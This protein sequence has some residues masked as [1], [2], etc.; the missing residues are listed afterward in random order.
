[1]P[2]PP[3]RVGLGYDT[4]KL[5]NGGPLRLGGIDIE[6]NVHAIGHSDADV[7]L[8]AMTDALLGAADLGDIGQLFPDTDERN[9]GRESSEF[10][11]E[12][13]RRV[14]GAGWE[15]VNLDSVVLTQRPKIA[16]YLE[17][18]KNRVGEITNLSPAHIGIKGKTG[19][20]VGAIGHAE[21]ISA[22]CVTL[23]YRT[24]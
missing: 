1:M 19:E 22:R 5:G 21:A 24:G 3:L 16:P 10:L 9:R 14:R 11:E 15:V 2:A 6:S 8:H 17:E 18:M 23:L 4:H 20:G 13:I 12:A 7:L